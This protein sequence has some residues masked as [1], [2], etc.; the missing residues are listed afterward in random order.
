MWLFVGAVVILTSLATAAI[1]Q[2]IVTAAITLEHARMARLLSHLDGLNSVRYADLLKK[3]SVLRR[4]NDRLMAWNARRHAIEVHELEGR[5]KNA[6]DLKLK[7]I[8]DTD[9]TIEDW[10]PEVERWEPEE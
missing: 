8:Y 7:S 6:T 2:S 5:P 1:V 9:S 10:E 4:Q 3:M